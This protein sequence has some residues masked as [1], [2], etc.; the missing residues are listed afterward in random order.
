MQDRMVVPHL[1]GMGTWPFLKWDPAW[2]GQLLTVCSLLLCANPIQSSVQLPTLSDQS[3]QRPLGLLPGAELFPQGQ[4]QSPPIHI[5]VAIFPLM[6]YSSNFK[7]GNRLLLI[8]RPG[9]LGSVLVPQKINKF[10]LTLKKRRQ[11]SSIA[12]LP[13]LA[14]YSFIYKC[15]SMRFILMP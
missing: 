4:I 10:F 1:T 8:H 6:G 13:H 9:S 3:P 2:R 5:L 14:S 15:W 12:P 11:G 7:S